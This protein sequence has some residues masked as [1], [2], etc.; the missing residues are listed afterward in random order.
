[1]RQTDILVTILRT[2]PRAE[3]LTASGGFV[4][5]LVTLG[6]KSMTFE[7]FLKKIEVTVTLMT[8]TSGYDI[9]ARHKKLQ[10]LHDQLTNK[11][12][13][14]KIQTRTKAVFKSLISSH[15]I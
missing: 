8:H 13:A 11:Y 1:M 6:P 2:L 7:Q 3:I 12:T 10:Q 4:C 14:R 9:N 5:D 15:L